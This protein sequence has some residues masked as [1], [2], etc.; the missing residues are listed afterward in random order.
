MQMRGMKILIKKLI[1][2]LVKNQN[3]YF[4]LENMSVLIDQAEH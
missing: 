3:F 4:I 1:L 2:I